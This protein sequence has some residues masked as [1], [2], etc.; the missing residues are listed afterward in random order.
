MAVVL[1][2]GTSSGFGRAI[3]L[4]LLRR[5]QTVVAGMR[6]PEAAS[7]LLERC[8]ADGLPPPDVVGL[9]V[10]SHASRS[11]AVEGTLA[12][13][14][15]IDV[16]VNNAGIMHVGAFEDTPPSVFHDVLATN[17]TGTLELTRCVLPAMRAEGAGR[18]VNV[19]AIGALLST[20][21]LSAYVASKHALDAVAGALDLELR[22]FG[23]RS[24]SVLPGA[25]RTA[26]MSNS[27]PAGDSPPYA[28][29]A[30]TFRSGLAS[31][32]DDGPADL[33]P[34]TD[35]VARAAFDP[36]PPQ[37]QVV[38]GRA[39][40]TELAPVVEQLERLHHAEAQRLGL[41]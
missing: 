26:I 41:P 25:F 23:I 19:T 27:A 4:D 22:P 33:S 12:R 34:I 21:F 1:V 35:A 6:R 14:R 9:D 13:H 40:G 16:L 20:P 11:A 15:R 5:G 10:T 31:R 32:I 28:E 38:A 17:V 30:S 29:L 37:R 8:R 24:L 3:C 39:M 18:I 36:D 2:S 7:E